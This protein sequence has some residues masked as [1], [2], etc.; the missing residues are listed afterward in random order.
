MEIIPAIANYF[1][2]TIDELFGY[3][4]D[5]DV[6]LKSYLD[7]ADQLLDGQGDMSPCIELLRNAISEFPAEWRLQIRLAYAL[8]QMGWKKHGARA[9]TT[10]DSDYPQYDI[11]YNSQN[12]YWKEAV[13][14]YEKVLKSDIDSDNRTS[15]VSCLIILYS[16]MGDYEKAVKIASSQPSVMMCKEVLLPK[17]VEGE[18]RDRYQGEA[19]LALTHELKNVME[20]AVYTKLSL[21]RSQAGVD[22]LLAV[23]RLCESILDDGNC[24]A[25]HSDLCMIYS[26]CAIITSRLKDFKGAMNYF[27][28][29][30][31][32]LTK[33]NQLSDVEKHQYT[34]PLV[35]KVKDINGRFV[36]S[37]ENWKGW[38]ECIPK[39]FADAIRENP[40]YSSIFSQ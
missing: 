18:M 22:K 40:K 14:L 30:F 4:N 29:A 26:D 34:A 12:E 7:H 6:K 2:I 28:I 16:E 36:I 9:F 25:V 3:N 8:D 20:M 11:L 27:D 10:D 39:E 1:H 33:F 19:L 17:A 24:G 37:Q 21:V 13:S 35:S 5:R 31:D 23:A 15:V 32:H 38:M